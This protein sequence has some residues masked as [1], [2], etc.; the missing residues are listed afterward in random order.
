MTRSAQICRAA[1][2]MAGELFQDFG[3]CRQGSVALEFPL[4]TTPPMML[5][6]SFIAAGAAA[7]KQGPCY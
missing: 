7:M 2:T 5:P 6:F 1:V 4:V 3:H